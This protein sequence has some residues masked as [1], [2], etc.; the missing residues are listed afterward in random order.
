VYGLQ[1]AARAEVRQDSAIGLPRTDIRGSVRAVEDVSGGLLAQR[2]YDVWGNLTSATGGDETLGFTGEPQDPETGLVS[3]RARWY[4]PATGRMLGRDPLPGTLRDPQTQH[5]YAYARNN[6]VSVLDPSGRS[7]AGAFPGSWPFPNMGSIPSLGPFGPFSPL[8]GI[9][10]LPGGPWP[11]IPGW[12]P[13]PQDLFTSGVGGGFAA[14]DAW[15]KK[16][17]GLYNEAERAGRRGDQALADFL[18]Y[19]G[20][21]GEALS[22]EEA[23]AYARAVDQYANDARAAFKG[24]RDLDSA[25]KALED[26]FPHAGTISKIGKVG[27]P[28]LDFATS[29]YDEYSGTDGST[30]NKVRHAAIKGAATAAGSYVGGAAAAGACVDTGVLAAAAWACG[31]AGSFVGGKIGGAA[32]D[33]ANFVIDK[34]F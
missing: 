16:I 7:A 29:G 15:V 13:S 8:P 24:S 26:E 21:I 1:R 11:Q 12:P 30:G 34:I 17:D 14:A 10:G 18:K 31:A 27:G 5:A 20:M 9:P 22:P 28:A 25:A 4:E 33:A 32:G 6:P 2:E 3:L 19:R 23:R